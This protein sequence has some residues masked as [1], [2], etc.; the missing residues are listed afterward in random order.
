LVERVFFGTP[1][2]GPLRVEMSLA[3]HG[4]IELGSTGRLTA[5][6]TL[7]S[8]LNQ[9][10]GLQHSYIW[11]GTPELARTDDVGVEL[12][13]LIGCSHGLARRCGWTASC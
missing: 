11:T 1:H 5:L 12:G 6:R 2:F 9:L 8:Y 3:L 7:L 13:Q 10:T 4:W